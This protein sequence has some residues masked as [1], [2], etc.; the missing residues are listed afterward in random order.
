MADCL[1]RWASPAEKAWIDI[2]MHGNAKE[3]AEANR[4]IEAERL[5]QEEEAKC[6]VVVGSRAELGR[7]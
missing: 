6:F 3:T 1:S 5:L 4:I 2:S 7:A